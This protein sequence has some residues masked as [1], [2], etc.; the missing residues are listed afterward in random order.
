MLSELY[1]AVQNGCIAVHEIDNQ[2]LL[3]SLTINC[4]IND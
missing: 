3:I 2:L 1:I 4:L